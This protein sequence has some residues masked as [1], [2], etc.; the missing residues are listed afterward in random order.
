[1]K[2]ILAKMKV[3]LGDPV[4]YELV[5]AQG[6]NIVL[7]EYL[8]KKIE[9]TFTGKL[10][11]TSCAAPVLKLYGGGC[12]ACTQSAADF[13]PCIL[14]P[15]LC[16]GHLGEGREIAF[17][18]QHHVQPHRVYLA[19]SS[20]V[21]VGVTR[22]LQVPTRWIDQGAA[23]AI[24]IARMPVRQFAGLLE[25]A[26]KQYFTDKTPWQDMV[27]GRDS[28]LS[29]LQEAAEKVFHY[30]P[31]N[32]AQYAFESTITVIRYPVLTYPT[33]VESVKLDKE[34]VFSGTLVG[35]RGQYL[36]LEDGRI[37]NVRSHAGYEVE[38]QV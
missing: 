28:S 7:N 24:S 16:R 25:V 18:M 13:S 17:E 1:M 11:C 15:E 33:S 26:L 14:R 29:H 30:F 20:A 23:A 31:T 4:Q 3:Q 27:R 19:L 38:I 12:Y 2:C 5:P 34:A 35:I 21:K 8:G 9:L 36:M 37:L 22:E 32:L 6:R 10:F